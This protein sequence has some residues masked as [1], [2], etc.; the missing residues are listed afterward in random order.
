M[1]IDWSLKDSAPD[2]LCDT[3]DAAGILPA[4]GESM[5]AF[6]ARAE[7]EL[8]SPPIDVSG[9]PDFAGAEPI[10]PSV[11]TEG[12]A[13]TERLFGFS[14]RHVPG[15][16]IKHG[17]GLFFGG[18]TVEDENGKT[19][20]ALR[21]S[22]RSRQRWFLYDRAELQA[23]E[24]CH[25]AR[26]PLK[27]TVYEEMLAYMTSGQ[28]IL[29]RYLGNFLR[30]RAEMNVLVFLIALLFAAEIL[31]LF[32]LLPVWLSAW[33]FFA[34]FLLFLLV[35]LI[36]NQ[37]VRSTYFRAQK[38]MLAVSDEPDKLL[39]RATAAEISRIADSPQEQIRPLTEELARTE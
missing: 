12:N 8:S 34:A 36:R 27:D 30:S 39:F 28:N 35:M 38:K 23:H 11:S 21:D 9:E 31:T 26:T 33:P 20:F 13:C 6:L 2:A 18:F 15:Y 25:A 24:Q 14:V 5:A 3:L 17:T 37:L 32:Q 29:R 22:F 19:C 10:P 4:P 7:K 1:F 16:F